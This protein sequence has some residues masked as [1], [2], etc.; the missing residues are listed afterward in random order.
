MANPSKQFELIRLYPR[1]SSDPITGKVGE[2]YYNTS[3]NALRV[4]VSSSPLL[5]KA[6]G[7]GTVSATLY[8]PVST[9]LPSG[10]SAIID[11]VTLVDGMKVLFSNLSS[12]NNR[13]YQVSGVGVS[14]AWTV[15]AD[16]SNGTDPITGERISIAQGTAFALQTAV[17]DGTTFK[18][19]D[20]TRFFSGTDYWEMSSLKTLGFNNN[21][22]SNVFSVN[23][24]GSENMI[25][26]YSVVRGAAKETGTIH[27]TSDGT[28]VSFSSG[29]SY[30]A[31]TGLLLNFYVTTGT[32]FFDITADNSGSNGVLKYFVRRWSNNPGGPGGPPSYSTGPVTPVTAAGSPGDVQFN[33]ATMLGA[34]TKFKWDGTDKAIDL[35]GIKIGA[36]SD[37][38]L[39][40]DNTVNGLVAQ[41]PMANRFAIISFGIWRDGSYRVGRMLIVNDGLIVNFQ[42]DSIMTN[43]P[44][45]ALSAVISGSDIL[46]YY[47]TV[48][49]GFDGNMRYSITKFGE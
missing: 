46:I 45:V 34:D 29:G 24:T 41:Y 11:G 19:N 9:T 15:Q 12:G 30:I 32:L 16:W 22:T 43:D 35:S 2:I 13:M 25:I 23:V 42:D 21:A 33:S 20:V 4:C 28:T 26:D 7:G 44:G 6:I 10:P 49:T 47:T 14:L 31:L 8:D 39:L 40:S 17:F 3:F 27:V 18:I 37:L 1:L 38:V 5:W 48:A 36:L